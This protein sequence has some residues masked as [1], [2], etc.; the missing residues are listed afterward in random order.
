LSSLPVHDLNYRARQLSLCK[1]LNICGLG[2][3]P[4]AII[5]RIIK[6]LLYP[7][8]HPLVNF[9]QMVGIAF[10]AN[11]GGNDYEAVQLG[12][13]F[14]HSVELCEGCLPP[15]S[16]CFRLHSLTDGR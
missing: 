10:S 15:P 1:Q 7:H 6:S 5:V 12:E 9:A 4:V 13:V 8:L 3:S 14:V 2:L 11:G 16:A